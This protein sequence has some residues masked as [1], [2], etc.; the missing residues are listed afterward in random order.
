VSAEAETV[1]ARHIDVENDEIDRGCLHRFSRCCGIGRR[2][3]P[4]AMFAK[5]PCKRFADVARILDD[6]NMRLGLFLI[7]CPLG[8][9]VSISLQPAAC[10]SKHVAITPSCNG[11]F[12]AKFVGACIDGDSATILFVFGIILRQVD[13]SMAPT[14]K[15]G[16]HMRQTIQTALLIGAL[17]IS[18]T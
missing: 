1:L 7:H 13:G 16:S 18:G 11:E 6:K 17:T 8:V 14:S 9:W 2:H 5:V 3:S 10:A 4:I 15:G 12:A